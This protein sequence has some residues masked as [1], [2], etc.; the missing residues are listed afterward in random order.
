MKIL[1]DWFVIYNS[2]RAPEIR[3]HALGGFSSHHGDNIRTSIIIEVLGE[4]VVRTESGSV[5]KLEGN[6][7]KEMPN[8]NCHPDGIEDAQRCLD[9][10]KGG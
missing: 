7:A 9:I 4:R 8:D 3:T 1:K 5:Y 6:P 2:Y 10:R